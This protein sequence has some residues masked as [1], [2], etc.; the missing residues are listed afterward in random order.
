MDRQNKRNNIMKIAAVIISLILLYGCAT[1]E[2]YKQGADI[3]E[4]IKIGAILILTGT[5]SNWG[6]NARGGA[7]LAID[8]LNEKGGVIGRQI[9]IEYENNPND[10]PSTAVTALNS[11]I[12]RDVAIVV[13]TTWSTSGLAVAPVACDNK[14]L[15]ISPSLGIADFNER[16]DYLLNLWP[17]DET[18][19]TELGRHIAKFG[20][21]RLAILG[22]QTVWEDAQARAVRRGF[23]ESGAKIVAFELPPGDSQDFKTEILRIKQARPDAVYIQTT[24]Q[25]DAA[26]QLRQMGVDAPL[27]SS[28]TD[29]ERIEGAQGALEGAVIMS[30]LTPS[31]GFTKK[32]T[33]EY[34][35]DPDIGS[36]TAYDAVM[37]IAKTIEDTGST[38]PTT[39]KDRLKELQAYSGESGELTFDG[40]GGVRKPYKVLVVKGNKTVEKD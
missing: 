5:G 10:D 2:A 12:A 36:D 33:A 9:E 30:S 11:L 8:E 39:L 34:G 40:R 29:V 31:E 14:V 23:E 16:C 13:G 6:Q 7:D 1:G 27:F 25:A 22:S 19:S 20:H 26:R 38:D 37:L 21:K 17:H 3:E 32:Y 35:M 18:L 24:F 15:M 28:L 4:P